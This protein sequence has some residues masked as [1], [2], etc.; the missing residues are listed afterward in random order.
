MIRRK[1]RI[2]GQVIRNRRRQLDLTQQEIARRIEVSTPYIGHLEAGKR[3]P[4][5]EVLGQLAAVLGLDRR[6]L[7]MLANPQTMELLGPKES[8]KKKLVW[9]EFHKDGQIR[10]T[11]Q[12]TSDEMELL[13]SVALMGEISS[14]RGLIYILNT[15]RQALRR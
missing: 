15:V 8:V 6:E 9:E 7:F 10:R 2:F 3:H 14:P 11:H 12:I 4:S 13:S 5:D 1:E